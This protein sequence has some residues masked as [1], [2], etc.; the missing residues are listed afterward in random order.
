MQDLIKKFNEY[1]KGTANIEIINNRLHIKIGYRTL[2]V[3]LP[4]I[5][6]M[7]GDKPTE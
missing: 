7:R 3:E 2:I 4:S 6:G 1:F 5:V